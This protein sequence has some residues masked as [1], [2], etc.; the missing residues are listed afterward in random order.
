MPAKPVSMYELEGLRLN[1]YFKIDNSL[2]EILDYINKEGEVVIEVVSKRRR[3]VREKPF[4]I[5][6]MATSTGLETKLFPREAAD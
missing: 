1:K 5:K 4:Y 3:G 6:I 2:E